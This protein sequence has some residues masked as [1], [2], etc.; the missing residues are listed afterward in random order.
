LPGINVL[1]YIGQAS[2]TKVHDFDALD[3]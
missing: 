1:A 2:R 3:K